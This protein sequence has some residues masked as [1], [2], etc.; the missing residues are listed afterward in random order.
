MKVDR[1]RGV[2]FALAM[3][4]GVTTIF[5]AC[6]QEP[7]PEPT[8][9]D[10]SG[11]RVEAEAQVWRFHEANTTMNSEAVISLLWSDF[12]ML[13]DGQRVSFEEVAQG[14]RDFMS[15]LQFIHTEWSDLHILPLTQ[16]L[17]LT[18]FTFRDSILT[19][20][21][22]LIQNQG[23]TTLLWE[24]RGDEWRMRFGDADH[25]PITP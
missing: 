13:V 11:V 18:S 2:C 16:D 19:R 22:E 5:E 1:G 14:S 23:P 21:G 24:R 8:P 15:S 3:I 7:P 4:V 6:T 10:L 25:Y 17:A 9:S 20:S 12:E